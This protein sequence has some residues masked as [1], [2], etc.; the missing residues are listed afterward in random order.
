MHE[1]LES[2]G[3]VHYVPGYAGRSL[4]RGQNIASAMGCLVL[5]HVCSGLYHVSYFVSKLGQRI[6]NQIDLLKRGRM[7]NARLQSLYANY[8]NIEIYYKIF[9]NEFD[10]LSCKINLITE[11]EKLGISVNG[12]M[13]FQEHPEAD[14]EAVAPSW[15][16]GLRLICEARQNA[17]EACQIL[18]D[19]SATSTHK[20]ALPVVCKAYRRRTANVDGQTVRWRSVKSLGADY[21]DVGA[22]I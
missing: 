17:E 2:N 3:F 1:L 11:F 8:P 15:E 22:G 18:Q 5:H 4:R 9:T 12:D 7:N 13:R 21:L 20:G 16:D 14:G 10:G 6:S 19:M